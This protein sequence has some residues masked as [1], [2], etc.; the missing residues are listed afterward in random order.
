M[1]QKPNL[2]EQ[3]NLRDALD[4]FNH[5]LTQWARAY[6]EGVFPEPDMGVVRTA[7]EARGITIDCV[8]ASNMRHVVKQLDKLF[9]PVRA[10]LSAAPAPTW[11]PDGP[12][13]MDAGVRADGTV[14]DCVVETYL[15]PLEYV[16][17]AP[18]FLRVVADDGA[19]NIEIRVPDEALASLGLSA[20][21]AQEP[22]MWQYR[23]TNPGNDQ[24]QASLD[25]AAKWE[26]VEPRDYI[27]T[28]DQRLEELRSYRYKGKPCYEV[29]ALYA[30]PLPQDQR[31]GRRVRG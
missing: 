16:T 9:Q 10:A 17:R 8:S 4:E 6:P 23:W 27:Q 28:L 7:L 3:I 30:S 11:A 2:P 21:P 19:T 25:E 1:D 29:R 5:H 31:T 20:A 12:A 18:G 14:E 22:V 15:R 13:A 26:H 24:D